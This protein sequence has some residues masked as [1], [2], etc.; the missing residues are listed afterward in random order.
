MSASSHRMPSDKSRMWRFQELDAQEAA[1]RM[2]EAVVEVEARRRGLWELMRSYRQNLAE[3]ANIEWTVHSKRREFQNIPNT[4]TP[5]SYHSLVSANI[6]LFNVHSP[7]TVVRHIPNMC[8]RLNVFEWWFHIVSPLAR[9]HS[10]RK[11]SERTAMFRQETERSLSI[12]L[13]NKKAPLAGREASKNLA[14]ADK[15]R[16]HTNL[17]EVD[18]AYL[19]PGGN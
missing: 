15:L 9:L 1:A 16:L 18:E 5:T 8:W 2:Q 12:F 7:F 6:Y 19:V 11:L 13:W 10:G 17:S 4:E 14:R 3:N